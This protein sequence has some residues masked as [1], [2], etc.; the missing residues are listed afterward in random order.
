MNYLKEGGK[1]IKWGL[2]TVK[3]KQHQGQQTD[4]Q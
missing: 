3:L 4:Q 2:L 1:N